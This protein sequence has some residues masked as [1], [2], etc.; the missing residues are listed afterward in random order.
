MAGSV[1]KR[2]CQE[3]KISLQPETVKN[4]TAALASRDRACA[5]VFADRMLQCLL[6]LSDILNTFN[7]DTFHHLL[8]LSV[9]VLYPSQISQVSSKRNDVISADCLT[10]NWNICI[11]AAKCTLRTTT[12]RGIRMVAN[13]VIMNDRQL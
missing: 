11:E 2:Q 5:R 3:S 7:D 6:V 1:T 10:K 12:Q 13:P 9:R 8:L 4:M